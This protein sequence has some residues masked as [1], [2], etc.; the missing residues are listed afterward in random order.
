MAHSKP[1]E[2]PLK[3]YCYIAVGRKGSQGFQKVRRLA[4]LKTKAMIER[5]SKS[6]YDM[7][8]AVWPV[9]NCMQ[10]FMDFIKTSP[11]LCH[12]YAISQK[13]FLTLRVISKEKAF[14]LPYHTVQKIIIC[15]PRNL[16]SLRCILL[17]FDSN[18]LCT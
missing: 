18:C 14:T 10:T 12:L 3:S 1:T 8:S 17:I 5:H 9:C 7:V 13:A 11:I 4:H 15:V 2:T 6:Q 16:I